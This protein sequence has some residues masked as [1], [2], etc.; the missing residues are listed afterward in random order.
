MDP[1]GPIA[2]SIHDAVYLPEN[3]I[4]SVITG[5]ARSHLPSVSIISRFKEISMQVA[6]A[7]K[8]HVT[9]NALQSPLSPSQDVIAKHFSIPVESTSK[10]RKAI[11]EAFGADKFSE[12]S[13]TGRCSFY[14]DSKG[15]LVDQDI[16]PS[17][18]LI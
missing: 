13:S 15:R 5:Y 2:T 3:M 12:P 11:L 7:H 14:F 4:T 9:P 16:S 1:L 8:R 17:A 18:Q 10:S 6:V